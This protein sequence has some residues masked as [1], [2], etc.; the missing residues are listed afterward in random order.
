MTVAATTAKEIS[1]TLAIV[2][3]NSQ[4]VFGLKVGIGP[5]LFGLYLKLLVTKRAL[6]DDLSI[7]HSSTHKV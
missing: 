4:S 7:F 6:S 1:R 5:K 2:W 3:M